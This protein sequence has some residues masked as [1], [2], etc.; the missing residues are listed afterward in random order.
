MW[1]AENTKRRVVHA[2]E[3]KP[4]IPPQE[5]RPQCVR[6][7]ASM[8]LLIAFSAWTA[9]FLWSPSL[10][11]GG[12][13]QRDQRYVNDFASVILP[14][15]RSKIIDVAAA[16][17]RKT[18]VELVVVTV[19]STKPETIESYAES[20]SD[21]WAIGGKGEYKGVLLLVAIEDRKVRIGVGSGV[22]RLIPD[23]LAKQIIDEKIVPHLRNGK[24]GEGI[25]SGIQAIYLHLISNSTY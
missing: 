22:S 3:G 11:E 15:Y 20:L 1:E 14:A 2:E 8:L 13:V 7:M 25:L 18:A 4:A 5:I 9:A 16:L 19:K 24:Y 10:L 23:A 17:E 12:E 6:N 21:H